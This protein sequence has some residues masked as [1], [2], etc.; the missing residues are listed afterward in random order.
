MAEE[1]K[2]SSWKVE[3][4]LD[5][6]GE[7]TV[8]VRLP[9]IDVMPP[10]LAIQVRRPNEPPFLTAEGWGYDAEE[11]VPESVE[12]DGR[13]L[14]LAIPSEY[15]VWI[16]DYEPVEIAL[17]GTDLVGSLPWVIEPHV[18]IG[19]DAPIDQPPVPRVRISVNEPQVNLGKNVLLQWE[20]E[21][22]NSVSAVGNWSNDMDLSGEQEVT[23]TKPGVNVFSLVAQGPGG[24]AD[25]S[26]EVKGKIPRWLIILAIALLVV[27]LLG[28]TVWFF[29]KK[30]PTKQP[31]ITQGRTTQG[32]T[33]QSGTTQGGTNQG[34]TTQGGTNQAES[35]QEKNQTEPQTVLSDSSCCSDRSEPGCA[36]PVG[37]GIAWDVDQ[38]LSCGNQQEARNKIEELTG[39]GD[40]EAA[41]IAAEHL[42][43]RP[44]KRGL[45]D[46]GDDRMAFFYYRLA[47]EGNSA[48]RPVLEKWLQQLQLEQS[49][50]PSERKRDLINNRIPGLLQTCGR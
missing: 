45:Y 6:S 29:N 10:K 33:N 21:H 2:A 24:N 36:G 11:L 41:L 3:E 18:K 19:E 28:A 7:R 8:L 47:C 30:P 38:M 34:E 5:D 14:L 42:G 12:R 50:Q 1:D 15:A 31:E 16:D 39:K 46:A 26:I 49:T 32:E 22:A 20:S 37:G 17:E 40:A 27:M 4:K 9:D 48:A 35:I 25:S 23:V 44:F 43:A 13:D